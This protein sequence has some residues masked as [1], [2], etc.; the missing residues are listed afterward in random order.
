VHITVHPRY[1]AA[2]WESA[3][4]EGRALWVGLE[5]DVR[6]E[7]GPVD[8]YRSV[9]PDREIRWNHEHQLFEITQKDS[10]TGEESL[11]EYV[12]FWDA[13]P[14]LDG[15]EIPSET[16]AEMVSKG[17]AGCV[18]RFMDFDYRFVERRLKERTEFLEKGALRYQRRIADRN[19]AKGVALLR[20][21]GNDMAAIL[22]EG[23]RW[24]P[25]MAAGYAGA[26]IPLVQAGIDLTKKSA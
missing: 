18:R 7:P 13:E 22:G 2:P 14:L 6:P 19:H 15:T 3:Q 25:A 23:R 9:F 16:V 12:F 26:R 1:V 21:H 8:A 10:V 5:A 17:G 24:L 20:Q 11:I 4:R